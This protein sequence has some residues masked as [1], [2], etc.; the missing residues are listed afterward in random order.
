MSDL[1]RPPAAYPCGSCP[2]RV[3]VPSGV[4]AAEEYNKLPAYDRPT[5]EQ[6]PEVFLCHQQDGRVCAGWAG[7]HDGSQLLALRL[8]LLFDRMT[9]NDV[10][11]TV[12]YVS[13][14]PLHP[15]GQAAADHGRADVPEPGEPARKL[16]EKLSRKIPPK[17][18]TDAHTNP[19][20]GAQPDQTT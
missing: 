9:P 11:T 3:D 8:A 7:C 16:I 1:I 5:G 12:D 6:P 14:V 4:W 15:T 10:Y 19:L 20:H 18:S 2:Y 13:P 17:E